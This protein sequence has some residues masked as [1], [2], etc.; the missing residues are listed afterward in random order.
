MFLTILVYTQYELIHNIDYSSTIATGLYDRTPPPSLMGDAVSL[1]LKAFETMHCPIG[2]PPECIFEGGRIDYGSE[3]E[4]VCPLCGI[5]SNIMEYD[6]S[7]QFDENDKVIVRAILSKTGARRGRESS[8]AKLL[9]RLERFELSANAQAES[10]RVYEEM[11]T[12]GFHLGGTG[13]E[14]VVNA[15]VYH[16]TRFDYN[17]IRM[18]EIIGKGSTMKKK[19]NGLMKR[20]RKDKVIQRILPDPL[21][22]LNSMLSKKPQSS[23]VTELARKYAQLHIPNLRP[24]IHASGALYKALQ[25]VGNNSERRVSQSSVGDFFHMSRKNVSQGYRAINE[26]ID[27]KTNPPSDEK[28]G[29]T[30]GQLKLLRHLR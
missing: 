22:T 13:L 6:T 4:A 12:R 16:G 20:L 8:R 15:S 17:F 24:D 2:T 5:Q 19:V 27:P 26:Q 10:I 9:D 14:A 25:E 28:V 21:A 23:A 3:G 18:E 30:A 11:L 1:G 29:L 7:P